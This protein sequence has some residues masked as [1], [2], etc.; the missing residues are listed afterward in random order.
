MLHIRSLSLKGRLKDL[1]CDILRGAVTFVLGKSGSGKSSLLRCLSYIENSYTG[2]VSINGQDLRDFS[3]SNRSE[4]IG[5]VA[6]SYALFPHKTVLENCTEPMFLR[7]VPFTKAK[8]R[9][10]ELLFRLG[11]DGYCERKPSS[12]S[13]GQQQR[14]AIARALM[15]DPDFLLFDEPTSALDPDNRDLFAS[16]VKELVSDKKGVVIATH[17]MILAEALPSRILFLE[18]GE[19]TD[20]KNIFTIRNI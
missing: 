10:F 1:Y 6:Q 9:A 2:L 17:D 19:L 14:V 16:I 15:L 13:G 7:K 4:K 5:F 12:L 18:N 3:P 11:M 8:E 20:K